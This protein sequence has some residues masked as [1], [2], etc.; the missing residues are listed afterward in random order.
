LQSETGQALLCNFSLPKK[1]FD[2][3]ILVE[4]DKAHTY[5]DG[6][7]RTLQY[8]QFPWPIVGKA[9]SLAPVLIRDMIYKWIARNRY[10]WFGK[11][12]YCQMP[13]QN[14][15]ARFLH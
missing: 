4:V 5:S 9:L 13:P 14:L 12:D 1:N 2:S 10:A 6:A 11:T 7:L 3:F 15:Q 8:L